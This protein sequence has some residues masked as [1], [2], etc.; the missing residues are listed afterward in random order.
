MP[1]VVPPNLKSSTQAA[2]IAAKPAPPDSTGQGGRTQG[3]GRFEVTLDNFTGPFDLLLRLIS[4]HEMDITDVALATVTDEFIS[5]LLAPEG[6]EQEWAL[7][8]AS[9]F[10]VLAATL[11]DLKAA[12]LLPAGEVENDDD[13]AL[14]EARD[15]LFARLLQYKAFKHIASLM[16]AELDS[17]ARRFPRQANL[18]PAFAALLPELIWR[19][20][21]KEFATLAT[22]ALDAKEKPT[23]DVALQHL[24]VQPV[25]VGDQ[26][27]L[28]VD[29]LTAGRPQDPTTEWESPPMSF[30]SLSAGAESS[31]VVIARFLALLELFRD[32]F[33][34]FTQ[35]QPL[36]ELQVRWC[37]AALPSG[38][39]PMP[40]AR[41]AN[42]YGNDNQAG[43]VT[44]P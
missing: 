16:E 42:S 24:H 39:S 36:G 22:R 18:E 34:Q 44:K 2:G 15:L 37:A 23:T 33:V 5:Y 21:P 4:K 17:E 20:T 3:T 26:S 12:R 40:A 28:L 8:E 1:A 9:E 29:M 38:H 32:Q 35:L 6:S 43:K 11:L 41:H 19:H 10:L 30:T 13:L 14:L 25:S 7:D 27:A 31:M